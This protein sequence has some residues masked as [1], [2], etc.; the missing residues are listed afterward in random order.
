MRPRGPARRTAHAPA[1]QRA[2]HARFTARVLLLQGRAQEG[3]GWAEDAMKTAAL[4]GYTGGHLLYPAQELGTAYDQA[5]KSQVF[6]PLGMGITTHDFDL[7]TATVIVG[8]LLAEIGN[9]FSYLLHMAIDPR[10]RVV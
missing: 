2:E 7:V 8:S 1:A 3:L 6:A 9:F 10:I 5:M 4:A